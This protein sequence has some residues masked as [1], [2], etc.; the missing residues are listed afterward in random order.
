MSIA[1]LKTIGLIGGFCFAYAALP[2]SIATCKAGKSIGTPLS[3]AWLVLLGTIFMYIYLTVSHGL[4]WVITVN[5]AAEAITWL[6]ILWYHY[7]PRK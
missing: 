3:L 7:F 6:I 4:D 5:Y 1:L 2:A